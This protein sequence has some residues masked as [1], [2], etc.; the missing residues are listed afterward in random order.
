M[1]ENPSSSSTVKLLPQAT[2]FPDSERPQ[3]PMSQEVEALLPFP[4][5]SQ[6]TRGHIVVICK[7]AKYRLRLKTKDFSVAATVSRFSNLHLIYTIMGF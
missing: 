3:N 7:S 1:N 5:S 2:L 4:P 6:D